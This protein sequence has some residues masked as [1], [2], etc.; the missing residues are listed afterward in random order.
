MIA[1]S[2]LVEQASR[3]LAVAA[4]KHLW[5]KRAHSEPRAQAS[6]CRIANRADAW[7][8]SGFAAAVLG[9]LSILEL[10]TLRLLFTADASFVYLLGHRINIV[11]AARERFGVPCPTCGLTRGFIL[12]LHGH[13]SDAWRLSP[14]GPLAVI[15]ILAMSLS[16]LLVAWMSNRRA[17]H[18]LSSAKRWVQT[19]ALAYSGIA[20][21]VWI[22][23]WISTVTRLHR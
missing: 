19:G 14:S 18:A 1:H 23:S 15:G 17:A 9:T 2:K 21:C 7:T 10:L 13:L 22:S 12:T 4:R 16:L 20:C 6:D 3:S 8:D 11:C 5:I